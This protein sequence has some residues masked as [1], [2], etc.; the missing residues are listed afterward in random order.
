MKKFFH[1]RISEMEHILAK[2][3]RYLRN[4]D[5]HT[6][7]TGIKKTKALFELLEHTEKKFNFKKHFKPFKKIFKLAGEVRDIHIE[8]SLIKKY[9]ISPHTEFLNS[10][11]QS[12]KEAKKSFFAEYKNLDSAQIKKGKKDID[13]FISSVKNEDMDEFLKLRA[14]KLHYNF[15]KN[16]RNE[17]KLHVLRSKLKIHFYSLKITKKD[18]CLDDLEALTE[19]LGKWHDAQMTIQ[20]LDRL[21]PSKG[22]E[23]KE[24][25]SILSLYNKIKKEKEIYLE[26]IASIDKNIEFI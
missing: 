15:I 21:F 22:M 17:K 4:E 13:T 23:I 10:L 1:K 3:P 9:G 14:K 12:E 16:R 19:L 5:F 25:K 7:R 24:I 8:Q 26:K 6:L 2:E 20:F 11:K 18:K